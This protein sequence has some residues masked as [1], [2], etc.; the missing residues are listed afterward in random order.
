MFTKMVSLV[1]DD[2]FVTCFRDCA[3][4]LRMDRRF[5]GFSDAIFYSG[6]QSI[7]KGVGPFHKILP[8]RSKIHQALFVRVPQLETE[9]TA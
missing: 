5:R 9:K 3:V 2:E 4:P 6:E 1:R 7:R 8:V